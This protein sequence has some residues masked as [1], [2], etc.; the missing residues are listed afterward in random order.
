MRRQPRVAARR[1]AC[2]VP[3][4]ATK[5]LSTDVSNGHPTTLFIPPIGFTHIVYRYISSAWRRAEFLGF[6]NVCLVRASA[7]SPPSLCPSRPHTPAAPPLTRHA[8][9]MTH[10]YAVGPSALLD[11]PVPVANRTEN[12]EKRTSKGC[13]LDCGH[14]PGQLTLVEA[15]LASA[16]GPG[17]RER[18]RDAWPRFNPVT[19]TCSRPPPAAP[20]SLAR[21]LRPLHSVSRPLLLLLS[22]RPSPLGSP[23]RAGG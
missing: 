12:F 22:T 23:L 2:G 5:W 4:A 21:L 10:C 13:S 6:S 11:K 18:A 8:A 16:L 17:E 3:S 15:E 7:Y 19:A 9:T 14:K 20:R 1:R